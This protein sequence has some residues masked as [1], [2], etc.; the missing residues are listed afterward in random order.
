MTK[1]EAKAMRLKMGHTIQSWATALGI[2]HSL[3][4][5]AE[6]GERVV[7]AKYLSGLAKYQKK[8]KRKK[9]VDCGNHA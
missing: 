3:A 7:S 4:V 5:K 8:Q 6:T 1:E 9:A 2:S